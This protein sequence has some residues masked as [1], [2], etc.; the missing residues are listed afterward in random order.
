[1]THWGFVILITDSISGQS[2]RASAVPSRF[3]ACEKLGQGNPPVRINGLAY[4]IFS[5]CSPCATC[6]DRVGIARALPVGF[7]NR[8]DVLVFL[9]N[10]LLLRSFRKLSDVSISPFLLLVRSNCVLCRLLLPRLD[11]NDSPV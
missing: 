9:S 1:M 7:C 2:Q 10:F 3:P 11:K 6:D 5:P 4:F 8:S